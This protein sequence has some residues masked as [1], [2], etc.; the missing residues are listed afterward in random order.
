LNSSPAEH[1]NQGNFQDHFSGNILGAVTQIP[2]VSHC[3]SDTRPHICSIERWE[4]CYLFLQKCVDCAILFGS[5][6]TA[7][8]IKLQENVSIYDHILMG[9]S[10]RL[11]CPA[12]IA[13]TVTD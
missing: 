2:T 3:Y 13:P 10:H 8:T 5:F 12:T 4:T 6:S 9:N 11:L 7:F 1:K